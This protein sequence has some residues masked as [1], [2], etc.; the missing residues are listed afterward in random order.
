MCFLPHPYSYFKVL[1]YSG[2]SFSVGFS[3][4]FSFDF[5]GFPDVFGKPWL[6]GSSRN[7]PLM[8][9]RVWWRGASP[10]GESAVHRKNEEGFLFGQDSGLL[11]F[12]QYIQFLKKFLKWIVLIFLVSWICLQNNNVG[13]SWYILLIM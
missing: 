3:W 6:I 8:I 13:V 5:E 9:G 2:V 11:L 10:W 7:G 1:C 4:T 12:G